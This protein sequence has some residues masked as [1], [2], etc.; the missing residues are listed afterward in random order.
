MDIFSEFAFNPNSKVSDPIGEKKKEESKNLND[1]KSKHFLKT[2]HL[3]PDESINTSGEPIM[4]QNIEIVEEKNETLSNSKTEYNLSKQT[5]YT[6][7]NDPRPEIF[8]FSLPAGHKDEIIREFMF[9]P[10]PSEKK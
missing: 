6:K 7:T 10:P 4:S 3:E 9:V 2:D 1:K 8:R 5:K